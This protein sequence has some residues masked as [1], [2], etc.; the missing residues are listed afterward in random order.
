MNKFWKN[1]QILKKWTNFEKMNKFWKNEQILKKWTNFEK[2][3]QIFKWTNIEQMKAL[4]ITIKII[5]LA[6]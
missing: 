4:L 3:E 5:F 1:E 2:N 6:T